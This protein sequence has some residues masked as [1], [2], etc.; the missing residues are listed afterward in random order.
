MYIR[1]SRNLFWFGIVDQCI[2]NNANCRK[3]FK[4]LEREKQKM[5]SKAFCNYLLFVDMTGVWQQLWEKGVVTNMGLILAPMEVKMNVTFLCGYLG[6]VAER[7]KNVQERVYEYNADEDLDTVSWTGSKY[8]MEICYRLI[9][10]G[11][12]SVQESISNDIE[13][14]LGSIG[15]EYLDEDELNAQI[16]R[17]QEQCQQYEETI[18]EWQAISSDFLEAGYSGVVGGLVENYRDMIENLKEQ[19][20][21]L[22]EKL[23]FLHE[24][25]DMTVNLFQSA[26]DLLAAI[27]NAI[28]DAGVNV[29]TDSGFP[30]QPE[31]L[32]LLSEKDTVSLGIEDIEING[33]VVDQIIPNQVTANINGNIETFYPRENWFAI[34]SVE[35]MQRDDE[36]RY[37]IAVAPKIL[38]P[39][40][41]DEGKIWGDDFKG[42]SKKVNV[43]LEN[44]TT[45]EE[46]TVKCIV[47][48]FKAHS[49]NKY[50]YESGVE[51]GDVAIYD[52]ESGIIQTGI[53]YP[54][55][56][57]A[58]TNPFDMNHKDASVIEFVGQEVDFPMSEY[59]LVKIIVMDE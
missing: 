9:A 24:A 20:A 7:Y 2:S 42:V 10:E 55:S 57:N 53:A 36:G 21:V 40:Y 14:L 34:G 58:Q 46:M 29:T 38:L 17:L 39:N 5:I 12:I 44:K 32:T 23:I 51:S 3:V 47:T 13:T 4:D 6:T 33:R 1:G 15:D 16:E 48:D 27:Q 41:P 50:P 31:W 59:R 22:K 37:M 52:I 28:N 54:N 56:V 45:G 35:G 49:Y 18:A 11:M 43:V 25:E 30:Q 8:K 19:I 26:M